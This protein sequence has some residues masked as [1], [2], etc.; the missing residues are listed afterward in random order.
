M[1]KKLNFL[2]RFKISAF[3]IKKYSLF[4]K[5]GTNKVITYILMLSILIGMVLGT[6]QFIVLNTLEE[7]LKNSLKQETFQFEMNEGVLDFKNSPY[8]IE[9]GV[10]VVIIDTSKSLD[11]S[12]SFR[13]IT[14]HK[15]MSTVFVKDGV[16]VNQNGDEYKLKYSE[17][18]FLNE[19]IN[20]EVAIN[21][22]TKAK[23]IKYIVFIIMIIVAYIS[24]MINGLIISL[25]GMISNKISG[26]KLKY[27]DIF[28]ISLYSLTLPALLN[29]VFPIGSL[30][31][32][33]SVIYTTIAIKNINK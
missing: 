23:P 5:E 27:K 1:E 12:E 9:E 11:E 2:S 19:K 13:S 15:D 21:I 20:N 7:G 16:I 10:S 26:S 22:L 30:I 8:K 31:I 24:L 25:L 18:P 3:Q 6:L 29:L 28:K 14:V 17:I 4:L 33:I 32:L